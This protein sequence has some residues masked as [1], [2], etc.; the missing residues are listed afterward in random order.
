MGGLG[1]VLLFA[2]KAEK[3][4]VGRPRPVIGTS[5]DRKPKTTPTKGN[6]QEREQSVRALILRASTQCFAT[7]AGFI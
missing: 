5:G 4:R 2:I 6:D 1:E 7:L 3:G